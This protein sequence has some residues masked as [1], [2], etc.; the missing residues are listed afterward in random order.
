MDF[1]MEFPFKYFWNGETILSEQIVC[2]LCR[3]FTLFLL[4]LLLLFVF[5][6]VFSIQVCSIMLFGSGWAESDWYP[7]FKSLIYM[8]RYGNTHFILRKTQNA[9]EFS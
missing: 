6:D 5:V 1:N 7:D 4:L 3:W 9:L 8:H 2:L